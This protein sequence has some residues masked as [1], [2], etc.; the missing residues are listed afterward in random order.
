MAQAFLNSII[1]NT[2]RELS[3][4]GAL[5]EAYDPE[6]FQ[7]ECHQLQTRQR[8][9]SR[10]GRVTET[11]LYDLNVELMHRQIPH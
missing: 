11:V 1:E 4:Q 8:Y 5:P 7:E 10:F 3:T 9:L 6:L 2:Y